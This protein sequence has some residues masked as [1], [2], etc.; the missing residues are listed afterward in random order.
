MVFYV[1]QLVFCLLKASC[2]KPHGTMVPIP[3]FEGLVSD[4]GNFLLAAIP[5]LPHSWNN[6]VL[7]ENNVGPA[8]PDT[9]HL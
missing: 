5:E 1:Q 7:E 9:H 8:E 4:A 6:L 2:S 3:D